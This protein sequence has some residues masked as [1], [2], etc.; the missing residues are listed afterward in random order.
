MSVR[1]GEIYYYDFL[2]G[3]K[4]PALV[5]QGDSANATSRTTVIAA[6]TTRI[7][8][9]YLRSH[10][11]LGAET[12]LKKPSMVLL[13]KVQTVQQDE[14]TELIGC[15]ENTAQLEEIAAG[16]R[17]L[18]ARVPGKMRCLCRQCAQRYINDE[19]FSIRRTS[20][21]G[22]CEFCPKNGQAYIIQRIG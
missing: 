21:S 15:V 11:L 20:G 19:R 13:E 18:Y 4:R 6:M 3:G 17:R 22:K 2:Q 9:L 8:K 5:I 1:Q 12:G 14:L 16:M 7:N 10:I